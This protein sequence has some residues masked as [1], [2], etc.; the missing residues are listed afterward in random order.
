[1]F[2]RGYCEWLARSNR[3]SP[4]N[5]YVAS[6]HQVGR[7]SVGVCGNAIITEISADAVVMT[8][9][10]SN[11]SFVFELLRWLGPGA[12]LIAPEAWRT[13][14]AAEVRAVLALYER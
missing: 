6:K 9:G 10:E 5:T 13:A 8:Y 2:V 7:P 14:F 3:A 1:M 11:R 12:E 4:L